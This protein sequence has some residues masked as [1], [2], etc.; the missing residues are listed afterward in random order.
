[1]IVLW[2]RIADVD[3]SPWAMGL[4]SSL[5]EATPLSS[6]DAQQVIH[7]ADR[8]HPGFRWEAIPIS[9]M[10]LFVVRGKLKW[11]EG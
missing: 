3:A 9:E 2:I 1:M 6:G 10:Q 5:L 7:W 8:D 4:V 11:D